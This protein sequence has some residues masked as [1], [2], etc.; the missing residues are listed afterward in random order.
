MKGSCLVF[1]SGGPTSVINSSLAGVIETA[2]KKKKIITN[3]YGSLNG[4][5]GVLNDNI[6]DL[7]KESKTEI[8]KL[9]QTPSAALG[10]A[11]L[12]LPTNLNDPIYNSI[13]EQFIKYNI[14]FVF[15]NGGND[16]MDSASKLHQFCESKNYKCNIIGIPKTIDNDL[17][18]TDHTPGYGSACKYIA[19][20]LAEIEAYITCYAKGRVTVVEIMG[21]DAGWLTASS[22]LACLSL[23]GPD[24]IYLPEASFN[25]DDF[26]KKVDNI[27]RKK[28]KVLVAVSE[29]I[30]DENGEYIV[31]K[32]A[33]NIENDA[34]GHVQLGGCSS[35]LA[36][37]VSQKL[38]ISTR[39]IEL[40]L[41]QR[42]ASHISSLTDINE[43]Y[44]CGK[45]AVEL[46][47]NGNSNYMVTMIRNNTENY[48]ITY[49]KTLLS[50]VANSIKYFPTNWIINGCDISNEFIEY[51]L[52][53]IRG[54]MKTKTQ[55]GLPIFATLKKVKAIKER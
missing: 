20:T 32:Y 33:Q 11:R 24:L 17:I 18:N 12:L 51:S 50:E 2:L 9:L 16:S 44:N 48:K 42:C 40:N 1:Q 4:I 55:N 22:K 10:S 53:L 30:K 38:N 49:G 19:T 31:K 7:S 43:A 54:N 13:L 23:N 37:I 45:H 15:V 36:N 6:V 47:I 46:A 41:P 27:Y 21:R 25:M 29:G 28:Q 8:K 26:L 52:P 5:T 35:I 34:F 39:S 3:V 14:R